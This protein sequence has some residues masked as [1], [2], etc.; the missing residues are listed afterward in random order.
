MD[1]FDEDK[2][3]EYINNALV[4]K[5]CNKY[6]HDDIIN[7]IDIIWEYYEENGMLDIDDED[8]D[9]D[10]DIAGDLLEYVTR[11]VKKDKQN[12]VALDDLSA[13]IDAE[14]AYE[15]SLIDL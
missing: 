2:A 15:D 3:V 4:A 5:G 7:I 10:E 13:I 12:N 8:I 6:S 9:D 14:L 11:M 1:F